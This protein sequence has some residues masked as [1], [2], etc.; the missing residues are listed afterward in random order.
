M[1]RVHVCSYVGP[2]GNGCPELAE[3]GRSRC[4]QHDSPRKAWA[5]RGSTDNAAR[6]AHARWRRRA[7][8]AQPNCQICG[9]ILKLDVHHQADGSPMVLC[10]EHHQQMDR[11]ARAR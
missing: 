5:H 2:D 4:P 6:A 3:P 8:A 1:S 7:I 9:S 11:H 10:N